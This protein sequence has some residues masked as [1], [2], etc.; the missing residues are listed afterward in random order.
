MPFSAEIDANI[1]ASSVGY[2]GVA[3]DEMDRIQAL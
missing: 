2:T 1:A 3:E